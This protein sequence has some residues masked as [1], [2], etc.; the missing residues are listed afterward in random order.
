MKTF[1]VDRTITLHLKTAHFESY[2]YS[3]VESFSYVKKMLTADTD[4]IDQGRLLTTDY[5]SCHLP[6]IVAT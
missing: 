3:Q 5:V 1:R 2:R 4:G 6:C